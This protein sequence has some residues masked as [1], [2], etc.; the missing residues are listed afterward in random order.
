MGTNLQNNDDQFD[1]IIKILKALPKTK[2]E[3]DFE[4]KLMTRIQ[5]KNFIIESE[6]RHIRTSWVL[7]PAFT[8]VA[9][10]VLFFTLINNKVEFEN[11]LM[12]DPQ[13][14]QEISA[15]P[16]PA[17]KDKALGNNSEAAAEISPEKEIAKNQNYRIVVKPNDVV[18][19]ERIAPNFDES[20]S[21]DLDN[22]L[23]QKSSTPVSPGRVLLTGSST[24]PSFDF[25]GFIFPRTDAQ[26]EYL[27][28]QIDSL[29]N[30][31]Q[32]E[33]VK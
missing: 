15:G 27:R 33:K 23:N 6:K 12:Q 30:L 24:S 29:R 25:D 31:R 26:M 20:K 13:I 28:K 8:A 22:F 4:F 17:V 1:Q 19:K 14:R 11:L 21:V 9:A 5:N 3:D 10:A 32:K 7:A 16:S 18:V 2:T